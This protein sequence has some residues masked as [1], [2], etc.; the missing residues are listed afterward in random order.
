MNDLAEIAREI[1]NFTK[2][3]LRVPVAVWEKYDRVNKRHKKHEDML[4]IA[5]EARRKM[6]KKRRA[7]EEQEQEEQHQGCDEKRGAGHPNQQ[8]ATTSVDTRSRRKHNAEEVLASP[9]SADN[10][11]GRPSPVAASQNKPKRRTAPAPFQGGRCTFGT[12]RGKDE[13]DA[14]ETLE[15][16]AM[17]APGARSG[18]GPSSSWGPEERQK[19][20]EICESGNDM[21]IVAAV[22]VNNGGFE[23]QVIFRVSVSFNA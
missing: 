12:G 22:V 6:D 19:L 2:A 8:E 11:S 4:A 1:D 16:R 21:P 9:S 5:A 3:G 18:G 7:K 17:H 20:N 14:L 10:L 13:G 15:R 23:T